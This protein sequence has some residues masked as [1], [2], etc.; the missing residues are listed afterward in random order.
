MEAP[1][2]WRHP[3]RLAPEVVLGDLLSLRPGALF[4]ELAAFTLRE[5]TPDANNSFSLGDG[6]FEALCFHFAGFA[7]C[8]GLAGGRSLFGKK[9]PDELSTSSTDVAP[10]DR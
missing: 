1:D 8:L 7:H 2:W 4:A 3:G 9:H 5:A 10:P 6:E